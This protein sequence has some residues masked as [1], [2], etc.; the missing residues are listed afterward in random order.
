MKKTF[1]PE[2]LSQLT[3]RSFLLRYIL[4]YASFFL[5]STIAKTKVRG[6]WHLPR[7]G[8]YV[9]ASNHFSNYDPPFFTYGIQK[10]INFIAASDQEV[11]WW[12]IWAPFLYGWIPVDR[13][14]LAP[15]TI[16]RAIKALK[17]EEVLG[18][19]PDGGVNETI[20]GNPKNGTVY[21][22]TIGKAPIV[23]MAIYGAETAIEDILKGIR[24][25]V[26]VNIGKP[27]GPFKLGGSKEKKDKALQRI[28]KD[29][30]VRIAALLPK[31]RQGPY[32]KN[33]E[34]RKRQLENGFI[35]ESSG[36]SKQL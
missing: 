7:K 35:P 30:M 33:S 28:G 14:K 15:S 31:D 9:V 17:N 10:P 27:F 12:L 6:R 1:G 36:E 32:Y 5:C 3:P 8:P 13:T 2:Y 19:F 4:T 29:M 23:P 21:L 16:K 26:F 25:R 11:E 34:I 20:L 22:S 18:I 24:P